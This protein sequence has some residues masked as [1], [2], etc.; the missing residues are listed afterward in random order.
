MHCEGWA[1]KGDSR[2]LVWRLLEL[3]MD[4]LPSLQHWIVNRDCWNAPYRELGLVGPSPCLTTDSRSDL[5]FL[6]W[7]LYLL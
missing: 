4:W 5:P 7:L 2:G 3:T 1:N 6:P